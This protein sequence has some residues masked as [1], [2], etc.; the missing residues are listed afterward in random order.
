M[1]IKGFLKDVGGAAR[2]TNMR[3]EMI[4]KGSTVPDPKDPIRGCR[5]YP[6]LLLADAII[7][8]IIARYMHMQPRM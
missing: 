8:L 7:C 3:R 2:V 1:K 4:A 5:P 6:N